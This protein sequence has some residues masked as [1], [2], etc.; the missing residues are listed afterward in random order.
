MMD[1]FCKYNFRLW[2]NLSF[3]DSNAKV[4]IEGRPFINQVISSSLCARAL[5][6]NQR[7]EPVIWSSKKTIEKIY[8]SFHINNFLSK[9]E[10]F[11]ENKKYILNKTFINLVTFYIKITFRGNKLNYLINDF[12][13]EGVKLGDL[14]YDSYIRL[15]CSFVRPKIYSFKFL[16]I[17]SKA[18]IEFYSINHYFKNN[19]VRF[20]VVSRWCYAQPGA[21]LS[22]IAV[23]QGVSLIAT[24]YDKPIFVKNKEQVFFDYFKVFK[25]NLVK[26]S[27][28]K[29]LLSLENRFKGIGLGFDIKTAYSGKKWDLKKLT[30]NFG[31]EFCPEKKNVFIM[32]HAFSDAN[33]ADG[34]LIF[35]DYYSWFIE[36]LNFISSND[37]VNWIV[38]KHPSL[39]YYNEEGLVEKCLESYES[40]SVILLP[41]E[42]N[43]LSI[44]E[45]ADVVITARGTIALEASVFGI[46]TILAGD[47]S[48]SGLGFTHEP[49]NIDEY[50]KILQNI[51]QLHK[52]TK[53]QVVTAKRAYMSYSLINLPDSIKNN[54]SWVFAPP[55]TPGMADTEREQIDI[56][57]LN[58]IMEIVPKKF[59]GSKN[60]YYLSL[61]EE[62][63][64]KNA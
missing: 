55:Y 37:E 32:L 47:S 6:D 21:Y 24:R 15:D 51:V 52:L 43:T 26:Y 12:S 14:I 61:K 9:H 39:K 22:R 29:F 58:T 5:C 40:T 64:D 35:R 19:D 8:R 63:I 57:Y 13:L 31:K 20:V 42:F 44:F 16:T 28:E 1:D 62:L 33:H 56:E 41:D 2:Q 3:I 49:K 48:F 4:L 23:R 18:L 10:Y 50:E 38:K 59:H 36:T 27:E 11:L 45:L 60:P 7:V 25:S 53:E 46:P 30:K 54:Q 34:R 17:L